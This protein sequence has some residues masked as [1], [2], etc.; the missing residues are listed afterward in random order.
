MKEYENLEIV[1]PGH[2]NLGDSGLLMHTIE[3]VEKQR[4]K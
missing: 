2:G 3:L 4:L 1:I